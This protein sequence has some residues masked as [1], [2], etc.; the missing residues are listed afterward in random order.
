MYKSTTNVPE[1]VSDAPPV[2]KMICSSVVLTV[3]LTPAVFQKNVGV[4]VVVNAANALYSAVAPVTPTEKVAEPVEALV[5]AM[6]KAKVVPAG[7]LAS[8][9]IEPDACDA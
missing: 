9:K 2:V 4:S 6:P 1:A 8:T 3:S 7:R 5:V